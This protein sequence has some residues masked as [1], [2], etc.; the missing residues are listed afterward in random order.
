MNHTGRSRMSGYAA[1]SIV[2]EGPHA[3]V[4]ALLCLSLRDTVRS[5]AVVVVCA[6]ALGC[7]LYEMTT[8]KHA[9]DAQSMNGLVGT[10]L[11]A[12]FLL[13]AARPL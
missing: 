7:I 12:P 5:S 1:S 10:V 6:Q 11:V 8:L 3:G 2:E 13:A 4:I 9:F